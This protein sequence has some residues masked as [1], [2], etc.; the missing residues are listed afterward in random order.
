MKKLT[1]RLKYKKNFAK[2]FVWFFSNGY[3]FQHAKKI[4]VQENTFRI[5]P[6]DL[7]D[8]LQYIFDTLLFWFSSFTNA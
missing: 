7:V 4:G 1:L 2:V 6:L 3:F 5:K 8:S